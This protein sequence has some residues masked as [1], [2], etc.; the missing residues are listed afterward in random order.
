[1]PRRRDAKRTGRSVLVM[2][3]FLI[4]AGLLGRSRA[5]SASTDGARPP[6][7]HRPSILLILPDQWRGEDLGCM[8]NPEV[9][10]PH[11][12]RLAA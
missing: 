7:G 5:S 11:L 12:D 9:R 8:G 4:A 6:Q 2:A 3:L 10:T 1:M